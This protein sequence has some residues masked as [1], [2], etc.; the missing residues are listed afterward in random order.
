M[1]ENESHLSAAMRFGLDAEPHAIRRY[2][3]IMRLKHRGIKFNDPGMTILDSDTFISC[4]PDLEVDCP[5]CGAGLCEIKCPPSVPTQYARDVK[6]TSLYGRCSSLFG[7]HKK[8][9][10]STSNRN[11]YNRNQK[12]LT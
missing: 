12:I 11:V 1:G 3:Q 6:A 8:R 10:R 7:H 2:K 5:C 9:R 4:T